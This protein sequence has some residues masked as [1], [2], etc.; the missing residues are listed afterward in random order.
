VTSRIDVRFDSLIV[1]GLAIALRGIWQLSH[2]EDDAN[3][4]ATFNARVNLTA[5]TNSTLSEC[6]VPLWNIKA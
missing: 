3:R 2:V 1:L 5:A 6:I 4:L